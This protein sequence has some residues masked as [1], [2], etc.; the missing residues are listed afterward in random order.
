M[1]S[2]CSL[3]LIPVILLLYSGLAEGYLNVPEPQHAHLVVTPSG[4][5]WVF[6]LFY[7]SAQLFVF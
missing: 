1:S 3:D 2:L 7:A 5:Y 6:T 4:T